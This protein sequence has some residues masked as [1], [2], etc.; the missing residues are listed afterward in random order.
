MDGLILIIV[1][2]IIINVGVTVG[3]SFLILRFIKKRNYDKRLRLIALI[4]ILIN[5]YYIYTAFYPT[6]SFYKEDFKEVTGLYFP[7]NGEIMYKTATYPDQ[8]G[9]YGSTSIVKVDNEF[10]ERLVG[11]LK[12]KGFSDNIAKKEDDIG[13]PFDSAKIEMEIGKKE[14][15][16]EFSMTADGG[17]FYYVGFV[18]D[19]ETLIIQRQSW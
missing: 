17:I 6:D 18:S 16:K 11:Q 15:E 4:P 10:Y 14:I 8:F 9:D 12:T 19:K 7:E 2:A 5:G 13:G 1:L 3:L